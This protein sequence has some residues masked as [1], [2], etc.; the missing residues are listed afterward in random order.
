MLTLERRK[1]V[2]ADKAVFW[3][4]PVVPRVEL[5]LPLSFRIKNIIMPDTLN[6]AGS[7]NRLSSI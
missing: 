7:I 4:S 6:K 5:L 1:N 3:Q 2:M